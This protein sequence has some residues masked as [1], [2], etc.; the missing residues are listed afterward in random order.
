MA[1]G[2]KAIDSVNFKLGSGGG[3]G[4]EV[5]GRHLCYRENILHVLKNCFIILYSYTWAGLLDPTSHHVYKT[6][7]FLFHQ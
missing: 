7:E 5:I 4:L 3:W 2:G 1:G 6:R